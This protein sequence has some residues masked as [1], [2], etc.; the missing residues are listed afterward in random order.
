MCCSDANWLFVSLAEQAA[1]SGEGKK[2]SLALSFRI[3]S[4]ILTPDSAVRTGDELS[5][6]Q[7]EKHSISIF[8]KNTYRIPH[9]STDTMYRQLFVNALYKSLTMP[10][11]DA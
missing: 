1:F 10:S 5:P 4:A 3:G 7:S 8:W 11:H 2:K 6:R 9:C